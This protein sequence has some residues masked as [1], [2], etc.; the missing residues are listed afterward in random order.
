MSPA[1]TSGVCFMNQPWR[2][3][4]SDVLTGRFLG[5]EVDLWEVEATTAKK[6]RA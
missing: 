3:F 5:P 4:P 6:A 1:T 2:C